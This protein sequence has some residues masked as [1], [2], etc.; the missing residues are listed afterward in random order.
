M[1][2][3]PEGHQ[4][5]LTNARRQHKPRPHPKKKKNHLT[6]V[7]VVLILLLPTAHRQGG[8]STTA[9]RTPGRE[10]LTRREGPPRNANDRRRGRGRARCA[11]RG[12]N[13]GSTSRRATRSSSA[14]S[15]TAP[16]TNRRCPTRGARGGPP[17]GC[18]RPPTNDNRRTSL[19]LLYMLANGEHRE[20]D[21]NSPPRK[22]CPEGQH[23]CPKGT[24]RYQSRYQ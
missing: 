18:S 12:R 19:L 3:G 2:N 7:D 20:S 10:C 4:R 5:Q 13:R 23:E 15:G 16:T 8:G 9:N 17:R 14:A 6:D 22:P 1:K 11:S 24:L 21:T